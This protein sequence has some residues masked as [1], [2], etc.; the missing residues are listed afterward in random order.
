MQ[1][2]WVARRILLFFS[3][4]TIQCVAIADTTRITTPSSPQKRSVFSYLAGYPVKNSIFYEPIGTHT[5]NGH[6][7]LKWFELMGFTYRSFF[8]MTF[9]NSFGDRTWAAG[10]QRYWYQH[11]IFSF[12][13]GVGLMV[14]YRGQLSTVHGIPLRNSFLFKHNLNP[15]ADIIADV[16]LTKRLK[17]SCVVTPLVI[18]VGLRFFFD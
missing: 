5:L 7:Q 9:I 12:G 15:A 13:Y 6:R 10:I 16:K 4:L 18:T 1:G 2:K 3:I 17:I 11:K 14:G 8:G